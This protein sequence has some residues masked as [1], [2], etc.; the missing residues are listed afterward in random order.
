MAELRRSAAMEGV[1]VGAKVRVST[2]PRGALGSPPHPFID[3]EL[4][5]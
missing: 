4:S 2:M 1:G 3:K 5:C